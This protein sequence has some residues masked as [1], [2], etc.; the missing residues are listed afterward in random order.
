[1]LDPAFI[2]DHIVAKNDGER[3]VAHELARDEHRVAEAE[4]LALSD[5]RH[6]D[7]LRVLADLFEL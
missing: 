2:R 7:Q 5:V 1:M 6:V 4:R 3:F